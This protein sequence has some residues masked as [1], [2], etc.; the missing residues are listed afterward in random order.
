[1]NKAI[2]LILDGWGQGK[3]R[4]SD[5]IFQANTPVMDNLWRT[6]PH[7]TLTTFGDQVGL[8]TGQMGNSEVGHMNI[9]AGRVVYQDLLRIDRDIDSGSFQQKKELLEMMDSAKKSTGKLHLIGLLS[10]GGVHSQITH[11]LALIDMAAEQGVQQVYIHAFLDGRDTDPHGGA[12]YLKALLDHLAEGPAKLATVIGRYYAMDRDKRWERTKKA[13]DLM[14]KG[15]G[16]STADVLQS[17]AAQ[18]KSGVTDEFINPMIAD[19]SG[20]IASGDTVMFFNYRADRPR[21]LTSMLALDA[22]SEVGTLPL[23]LNFFSMTPYDE[24]YHSIQV[25]YDKKPLEHTFGHL[26]QEKRLTQLRMAETEKYPHVT[27][28]FSGGHEK[29]FVGERRI[30]ISSP[31]VATYDLKPSMS[32]VELTDALLKDMEMNHTDFICLNFANT[33]MV[34]HTGV[35]SAAM[36]AAETVD[37]CVGRILDAALPLGYHILIIA[38]HG[39]SDYMIN[40]D[41]T[42]N[43]A[44]T[45]NPVPCIYVSPTKEEVKLKEGK[46]AD[47]AATLADIMGISTYEEM[48]GKTLIVK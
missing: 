48:N 46:L 12:M 11:L 28:F 18:Y 8:P 4:K 27:Y 5:A 23:A 6:K 43:T 35:F 45:K 29:P 16:E 1:M 2:L 19:S 25:I 3:I 7:T 14:V 15:V 33:D 44:H 36:E 10:D 30:M 22:Y 17:L 38:D 32:A 34:G 37:L 13:Y 9:G 39:N 24:D 41:G 26:L 21:Q 20:L 40:E 31:K 47:V 42:P